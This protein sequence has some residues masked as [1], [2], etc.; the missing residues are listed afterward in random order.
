MIGAWLR[1]PET[2]LTVLFQLMGAAVFTEPGA[3]RHSRV[4]ERR[5]RR[6]REGT[7]SP[8]HKLRLGWMPPTAPTPGIVRA[9][10]SD[11]KEL[12]AG[13]GNALTH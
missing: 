2:R 11:G 4:A 13:W 5:H 9:K 3:C 1:L 7:N 10:V 6:A 12:R 8:G